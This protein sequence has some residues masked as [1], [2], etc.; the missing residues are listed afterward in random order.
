LSGTSLR[1]CAA[2]PNSCN[3]QNTTA[4]G[5]GL[6]CERVAL[7]N[8][9][10]P[11][12]AE[13]PVPSASPPGYT[14]NGD[15]TVTDNITKLIWEKTYTTEPLTQTAAL[16]Y[17]ATMARTGGYSDW[18]LPSKI[19]LLSIVDYGR[20]TA[21]NPIFIG[22]LNPNGDSCW[23]STPVAG[24]ASQAWSVVNGQTFTGP[25]TIKDGVRCVR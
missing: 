1:S 21:L 12:W 24:S 10:D 20:T 9:A 16:T 23:S 7:A 19:E 22:P 18:R 25:T 13:W 11:Q 3:V 2:G 14:D 4:C 17:C 15:G 6:V 8:C 5:S